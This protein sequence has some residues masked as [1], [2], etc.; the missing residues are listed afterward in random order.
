MRESTPA[1][2]QNAN[3]APLTPLPAQLDLEGGRHELAPQSERMRLFTPDVQLPGQTFLEL[4][5]RPERDQEQETLT[6]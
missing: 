2:A 3:K 6:D 5:S 4:D 1:G